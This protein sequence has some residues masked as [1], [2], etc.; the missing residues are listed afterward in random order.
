MGLQQMGLEQ[1]IAVNSLKMKLKVKSR[2]LAIKSEY[3]SD[4]EKHQKGTHN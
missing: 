3:D 4:E 1:P 2:K